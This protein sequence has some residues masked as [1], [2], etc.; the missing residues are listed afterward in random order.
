MDELDDA[1]PYFDLRPKQ[2]TQS[3]T[4]YHYMSTR[5]NNFSNRDQK[6]EVIVYDFAFVA[7]S[8][9]TNGGTIT[10][11]YNALQIKYF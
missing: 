10:D 2:I 4:V 11:K 7:E 1:S 9:G 5:N 6:G 3:N 8:L